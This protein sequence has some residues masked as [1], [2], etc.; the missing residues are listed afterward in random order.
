MKSL[1][2][3][4]TLTIIFTCFPL[5]IW[6]QANNDCRDTRDRLVCGNQTFSDNSDGP[7]R[8]DFQS[9]AN[10]QGCLS[11]GEH[12]SAWYQIK[13]Q[14]SGT[15]TFVIDPTSND[16]YD[17]AVYGPNKTC[18][19]LGSP[20]RCS[21]A[22]GQSNTGL[23]LTA[24]DL[25]EGVPGD[26]FVRYLD[27]VEGETY[28]IIVD[29]FST[30]NNGFTFQWGGSAELS[31]IKAEFNFTQSCNGVSMNN[32]SSSCEGD[33]EYLW[34]F[35]DGSPITPDNS[36]ENPTHYYSQTGTYTVTLT[37]TIVS[38][39]PNNGQSD[40]FTF[41]VT[42]SQVPPT[43]SI[44]DLEE[45]Y[46]LNDTPVTLA[47]SPSGG[48]FTLYPEGSTTGTVITSFDPSDLGVGNYTVIY[49][50]TDPANTACIGQTSTTFSILDLPALSFTNLQDNYCQADA[51]FVLQ[52]SPAGGD[53]TINGN[54]ATEFDA[55]AL[56]AGTYEVAY[57]YT[58]PTT[59]CNN[60]ISK[61]VNINIA[62]ELNFDAL[63]DLYC[64]SGN[65]FTLQASPSGGTFTIDGNAATQFSP[66]GLG[67]G[68]YEVAY[69][70][71][72]PTTNCTN[73]TSRTVEV[74]TAPEINF[75]DLPTQFCKEDAAITLTATPTGGTFTI[76]GV[77]ATTF[78]PA[79]LSVGN[80]IVQYSYVDPDD[81][82][83]SNSA[84]QTVRIYR[85]PIL[86]WL[87]LEDDYCVN[88]D[89]DLTPQL[90]VVYD[91]D[92]EEIITL[93]SFNP[94]AVGVGT[95]VI[96][97]TAIDPASQCE[98]TIERTI[99]INALP[100][101]SFSNV[102][103]LYCISGS[104]FTM[105]ATPSGG[106]F[107]I[108]GN[109]A[110]QFSPAGFGLGSYEVVY[111]YTDPTTACTNTISKTVEVVTAPEINFINLPT[112]VCKEGNAITLSASPSGGTF[113]IDGA[114]ATVFNP[115]NL[116]VGNHIVQYSYADPDDASCS[117]SASQTV[118]IYR[119]PVLTW[120]NLEDNYCANDNQ[121]LT[122]QLRIVYDDDSEETV[123]LASFNP[124]VVGVGTQIIRYTATDPVSQCQTT[125]ERSIIINPIPELAFVNLADSY[126]SQATPVTLKGSPA[127]G[128]FTVNGN[129]VTRF[130]PTLFE[131]GDTPLIRYTY[132]DAN[133]CNNQI[134][135]TI[136]ITAADDFT[137]TEEILDICPPISGYI[138][139]AI[140]LD[141]IPEGANW[142]F[143]W[144]PTGEDTRTITILNQSQ[145][146][147]YVVVVR[148]EAG[149]PVA[150]K[151]F[152][153]EVDCE[154]KLLLPTAFSPNNDGINDMLD[155][156]DEDISRLDLRIYNRWGEI[157]FQSLHPDVKWDGK[158]RGKDAPVGVYLWQATYENVLQPGVIIQQ[159]G[160]VNLLR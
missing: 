1:F 3:N 80:H 26:G 5:F 77:N 20:I 141:E 90:R 37:A 25:S 52:A 50:Y 120:L 119:N 94:T 86:T 92:S 79:N 22:L 110:T 148:D 127:G 57:T 4:L 51:A 56:G 38:S 54:A 30:T 125:I 62:P 132:S 89:Q 112:Q 69:T 87:N 47:A 157:V 156:F 36:I 29:N 58:D 21:Y 31:A 8:N 17:F 137:P 134:S 131:V 144:Q 101:L 103:D 97:Y 128:T 24:T 84:S 122:P 98:T 34:D 115:A 7:G 109:I 126:C 113:T 85:N 88:D 16:D 121:D 68:V 60:T 147:T 82:S 100:E 104:V 154:P 153:V 95:Q 75:I 35:G 124:T 158:F 65:D 53:F 123:T 70:Y 39:G 150:L 74:V 13:I 117:N 116:S 67:V 2:T 73:T 160:K 71:T 41:P 151:T 152:V 23:S 105:Q 107:T 149:C 49:E 59:N 78:D 145:S 108:D 99:N 129:I 45:T 135:K 9:S 14:T 83:C 11:T 140:P 102:R 12:E 10:D 40:V 18:E 142:T 44:T 130:E 91:D 159:Q 15:L 64:I 118:R 6:A 76:D 146:G 72:D 43:P 33:I 138:L 136:I 143:D 28:F 66:S 133:G 46:C 63:R 93:D 111:T 139:E 155:I 19:A 114:S 61:Q 81:A 42:V 32:N 27:V 96:S 48:E 106:S 55:E